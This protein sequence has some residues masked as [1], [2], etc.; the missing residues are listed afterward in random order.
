MKDLVI[1]STPPPA[2]QSELDSLRERFIGSRDVSD[3][4]R[5]QY[6]HALDF[7]L[8]WLTAEGIRNPTREDLVRYKQMLIESGLSSY[9]VSLRLTTL[10]MFFSWLKE[11]ERYPD[12]GRHLKTM[13]VPR[14]FSKDPLTLEQCRMLLDSIDTGTV[15]GLR[16]FAIINLLMQTGLRTIEVI[17]ADIGDMRQDSGQPVLWVQGKG[18]DTKDSFVVLTHGT[19]MPIMKY[20][21]AR[22]EHDPAAPLF[23]STSS[24]NRDR[25]LTTRTIRGIVKTALRGIGID[26]LRISAHS[27][28]HTAITLALK[29]GSSV[30]EVMTM[31]RHSSLD[32]T[33]IYSHN[34]DRVAHAPERRIE[35]LLKIQ[36]E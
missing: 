23:V 15:I 17:R 20:L 10:R 21:A 5:E 29:A 2:A 8:R 11:E 30:Q 4:S 3:A 28:R 6:R 35:N 13:K 31:A 36:H 26:S 16:D 25:R 19:V 27:L 18:R 9:T 14:Q 22:K 7:F 24:N 1:Y 33:L 32:T 12:I 34:M